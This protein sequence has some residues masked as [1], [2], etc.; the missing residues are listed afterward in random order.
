MTIGPTTID[1]EE[2]LD[3]LC[4]DEEQLTKELEE[5]RARIAE[6]RSALSLHGKWRDANLSEGGIHDHIKPRQISRCRTQRGR[7]GKDRHA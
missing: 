2:W 1:L 5:V 4:A 3:S 6:I 7:L